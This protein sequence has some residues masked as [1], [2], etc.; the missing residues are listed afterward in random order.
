MKYTP[1]GKGI[2]IRAKDRKRVQ[3]AGGGVGLA[4]EAGQR[5]HVCGRNANGEAPI[6]VLTGRTSNDNNFRKASANACGA[7]SLT[8]HTV[9]TTSVPVS[10]HITLATSSA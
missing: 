6:R 4:S 2:G 7:Q 1:K 9:M 3:R 5:E 8:S 10:C